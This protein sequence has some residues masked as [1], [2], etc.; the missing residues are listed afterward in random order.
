[1]ARTLIAAGDQ[2]AV[3]RWSS[4]L[5]LDASQEAYWDSR[6]TGR[7]ANSR[8]PVQILD[9]LEKDSGDQISFDLLAELKSTPIFGDDILEHNEENQRLFTDKIF[10]DQMRVG[11]NSG[12]AVTRKRTLHDLRARAK[13]QMGAYWA[14]IND[15]LKFMYG[16]G[17]RGVNENFNFPLNYTGH[18]GNLF[19]APDAAHR[20]FGGVATAYNNMVATDKF[21]LKIIDKA[22]TRAAVQG[23]GASDLT[24]LQPCKFGAE[25]CYVLVMHSWQEDDMR[26]NSVTGQW[27]DI[28]RA[29]AA[30][31]G[32][33]SPLFTGA[34]GMYR[35]VVLHSHRNVIRFNNAGAGSNVDAARAIFMG[36]QA[37]VTAFGSA[38]G[39]NRFDWKEFA[40]DNGNQFIVVSGYIGG[41]KKVSYDTSVG[42]Q[43]FGMFSLDTAAAPR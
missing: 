27:L 23:G 34:L 36:T 20:I 4:S 35:G 15:Q 31:E 26:T 6:F 21:D 22:V 12:G 41:V 28:Q 13:V 17:G 7:G 1:M 3:K 33:K 11:V 14:S 30:A 8:T 37:L 25:T 19:T 39:D 43:D 32:R 10:I 38:N 18:A 24:V 2:K 5:S 29:A 40:K 9:D 16:C 42:V